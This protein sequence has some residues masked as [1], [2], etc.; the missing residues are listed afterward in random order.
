MTEQRAL[1]YARHHRRSF[2]TE[3]QAFVAF[4]SVS[5][6]PEHARDIDAVLPGWVDT[7]TD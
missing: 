1:A 2:V 4:P 5:L 6:K 3:L 7:C